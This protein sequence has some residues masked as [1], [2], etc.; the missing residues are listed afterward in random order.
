MKK[1][2]SETE[3]KFLEADKLRIN[4]QFNDA[5]KILD[6]IIEK[7]PNFLPALN[8]IALNYVNLK[9]FIEAEKYYLICLNLKPEELIFINNLSKVF[10]DTNQYK[11]AIPLLK[12]SLAINNEQTDIVKIAA[13][14]LFELNLT[15]DLDIFLSK[16]IKKYPHDITLEYFYGRNLLKMNKHSD[17]LSV[18][19]KNLGVIEFDENK[20]K[21]I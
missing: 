17:G 14:C 7:Y 19:K 20:F 12:K 10:H 8:N 3:R 16:V 11:K 4:N 2:D 13:K 15:K 18:L 1:I 21:I 6:K 5:I 9:N